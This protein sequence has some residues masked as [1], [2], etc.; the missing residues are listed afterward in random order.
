[1]VT[2]FS[3]VN[4]FAEEAMPRTEPMEDVQTGNSRTGRRAEEHVEKHK[5]L[6]VSGS[7]VWQ[8]GTVYININGPHFVDRGFSLVQTQDET[9]D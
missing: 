6:S 1:M 3:L 4:H 9:P 8:V 2:H 7:G 5:L